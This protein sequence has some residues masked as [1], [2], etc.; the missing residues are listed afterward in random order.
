LTA[1]KQPKPIGEPEIIATARILAMILG[2]K[3]STKERSRA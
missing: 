3:F 2:P 1:A